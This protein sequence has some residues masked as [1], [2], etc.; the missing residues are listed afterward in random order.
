MRDAVEL[1]VA[2]VGASVIEHQDGAR[3][4]REEML[5]GQ[6]LAAIAERVLRQEAQFGE[7]V[8]DDARWPGSLDAFHHAADRLAQFD[9]GRIQDRLLGGDVESIFADEFEQLDAVK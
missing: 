6:D 3:A 2:G 1:D 8:E 5:Q 9:F 4:G 7:A